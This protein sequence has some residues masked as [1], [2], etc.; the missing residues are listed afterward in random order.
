MKRC[1]WCERRAEYSLVTVVS[2]LGV[3]GRLQ[4]CSRSEAL[5]SRCLRSLLKGDIGSGSL[6]R[7]LVNNAYTG[8][9]RQLR[10]RS[11]ANSEPEPDET[12]DSEVFD[13][14]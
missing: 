5:C 9:S 12:P 7:E 13:F 3:K 1:R 8:L 2:T 11:K 10:E 4:K 6:L 14:I